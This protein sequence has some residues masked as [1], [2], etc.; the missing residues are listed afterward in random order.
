MFIDPDS[1]LFPDRKGSTGRAAGKQAAGRNGTE[2][3]RGRIRWFT[4]SRVKDA[5]AA[6]NT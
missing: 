5:T 3:V 2:C 1:S 6:C 4:E